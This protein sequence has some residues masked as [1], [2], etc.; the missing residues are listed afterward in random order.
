M[1]RDDCGGR[2]PLVRVR[3]LTNAGARSRS[4]VTGAGGTDWSAR[5]TPMRRSPRRPVRSWSSMT[6]RGASRLQPKAVRRRSS[7]GEA[8][9]MPQR[10]I[11]AVEARRRARDD[12]AGEPTGVSERT[13]L[14]SGEPENLVIGSQRM[15]EWSLLTPVKRNGQRGRNGSARSWGLFVVEE[16]GGRVRCGTTCPLPALISAAAAN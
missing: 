4:R 5:H 2:A 9:R 6:A 13:G 10:Q 14:G 8:S 12:N 15:V 7:S 16:I 11:L 1:M 3:A